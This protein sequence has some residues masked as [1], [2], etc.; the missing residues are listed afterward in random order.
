MDFLADG[1]PWD[2]A[3]FLGSMH[4]VCDATG[5]VSLLSGLGHDT[6]VDGLS[7]WSTLVDDG[8]RVAVRWPW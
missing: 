4:A 2:V 3:S 1:T 5:G 8:A 6:S 7:W